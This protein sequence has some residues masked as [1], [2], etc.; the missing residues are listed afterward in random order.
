[1]SAA[2]IAGLA[3]CNGRGDTDSDQ[4]SSDGTNGGGNGTGQQN[5]NDQGTPVEPVFDELSTSS[6]LPADFNWNPFAAQNFPG[7]LAQWV[8]EY[9]A[10]LF[11]GDGKL[12]P[13][14]YESWDYDT[15]ND[16]LTTK[17]QPDLGFWNGDD[18]TAH[19]LYTYDELVRLQSPDSS[20]FER[21]EEVDDKTLKYHLKEPRNPNIYFN[22]QLRRTFFQGAD[23]W[24]SWM[25]RYQDASSAD[26]RDSITKELTELTISNE[27]FIDKGLGHGAYKLS[28]WSDTGTTL[29][30]WD[31][32]RNAGD[33]GIET[34]KTQLAPTASRADQLVTNDK[35]DMSSGPFQQQWKG[36]SPDHLKNLAEYPTTNNIKVL[37][38]WKNRDYLQDV[39]F[40]RAIA[41]VINT[42]PA[43][44]AAGNGAPLP[45]HSGMDPGNSE[46]YLGD[47][48]GKFIDYKPQ[49]S[50]HDLADEFLAKSGYER[51]NGTIVDSSGSEIDP[52]RFTVGNGSQWFIAGRVAS[53]QMKEYG[54]PVEFNSIER[55]TK[56][57]IIQNKMGD[58]DLSTESHY[59]GITLHPFSYFDYGTFWGWRLGPAGYGPTS[60]LDS[61][62]QGWLDDGEKFSPYNGKP[63]VVEVPEEIGAMTLDGPTKE[64]NVFE[65]VNEV[66]TPI[67]KERT[68]E[69]IT[70]LSWAWN[71]HL[72][73][74]DTYNLLGGN[75]GDTKNYQWPEEDWPATGTN[76]TGLYYMI[77][78]GMVDHVYE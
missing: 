51:Q 71:F 7:N 23:R 42:Q 74:I 12:R 31:G 5:N 24:E 16:V 6:L 22:T 11:N 67:S 35:I 26:Q 40:R 50:A 29:K 58:W 17:L 48:M 47:N 28:D 10:V 66:Q 14:G 21:I 49:E 56:V 43:A 55:S 30:L 27:E 20:E 32:H 65:L 61:Q 25:E 19:D 37:I 46:V 73:D 60:G 41:A 77:Q 8:F 62:I 9:G 72:P 3:G 36:A 45:V 18:F 75:W 53:E 38:N 59:A 54:F 68:N 69:I 33:I 4:T 1:M 64:V 57:D 2:T 63:L 52:I 15:E 44:T 76:N 34:A 39:N 70:D 78:N 13:M